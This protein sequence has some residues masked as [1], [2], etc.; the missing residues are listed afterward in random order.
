MKR[1]LLFTVMAGLVMVALLAL[2][3]GMAMADSTFGQLNAGDWSV[4]WTENG[5]YNGAV[6]TFDKMEVFVATGNPWQ[7]PAITGFNAGSGWAFNSLVN[8]KYGVASGPAYNPSIS[9][10]FGFTTNGVDPLTSPFIWDMYLSLNN[11]IVG[12]QRSTWSNG[13]W[14]FTELRTPY[15]SENRSPVPIPPSVLLFGSGLV[16]LVGL[17]WRGRKTAA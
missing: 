4:N 2:T 16:G 12:G 8:P 9:G 3:P 10:N 13:G 6:Q 1:K 14:S 5:I 11:N 15:P 17:R 7:N